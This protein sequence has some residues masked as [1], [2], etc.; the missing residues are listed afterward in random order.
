MH[1]SGWQWQRT[2]ESPW[3]YMVWFCLFGG[4]VL[5]VVHEKYSQRQ[6]GIERRF[7]AR[8]HAAAP[9]V[10]QTAGSEARPVP[11]SSPEDVIIPLWPVGIS[12]ALLTCVSAVLAARAGLEER[13]IKD[14]GMQE[15]R[16]EDSLSSGSA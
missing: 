9:G 7:Q 16:T 12:L 1:P 3:F 2:V 14:R 11:Y 6:S 4:V 13:G 15:R 10:E 5:G 8:S